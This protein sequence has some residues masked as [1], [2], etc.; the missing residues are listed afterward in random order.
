MDS[1]WILGPKSAQEESPRTPS[2]PPSSRSIVITPPRGPHVLCPGSDARPSLVAR[3][4]LTVRLGFREGQIPSINTSLHSSPT[5][6]RIYAHGS[7]HMGEKSHFCFQTCDF[8]T[9]LQHCIRPSHRSSP[10][11]GG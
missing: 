6:Y 7:D 8:E 1:F 10:V 5:L 3:I 2:F 4:D 9:L 11:Q